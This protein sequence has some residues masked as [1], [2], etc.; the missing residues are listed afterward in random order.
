MVAA[1]APRDPEPMTAAVSPR[2]LEPMAAAV[3]PRDPE[4]MAAAVAPRDP[5]PM[6]TAVPSRDPEP[7]AAAVVL[8]DPETM[9]AAVVLR[10][11]EPM[12][13]A[14][15]DLA[16]RLN[17]KIEGKGP[18]VRPEREPPNV[19][20]TPSQPPP[21]VQSSLFLNK[22]TV[23]QDPVTLPCQHSFCLKCIEGVW[24]QTAGPGRF[25]CPQCRRKFNPTPSLERNFTLCNIV[26][27]YN[28]QP[29]VDSAHVVCDYCDE[30]PTPAVKTCLKCEISLCSLH[31]K[32]HLRNKVFSGHTLIEPVTDLTDRQCPDHKEV[33]KFYCKDDAECV[34]VPCAI[35]GKH[36]S[37]TLLSLDE[38]QSAIKEELMRKIKTFHRVQQNCSSKQ[39]DLEKSEAEIKKQVNELK[40]KFSNSF[41]EWRRKME[42]DEESILKLIDEEGLRALSQIRSCSEALNKRMKQI[43]LI[44]EE[45][46]SLVQRDHLSFIQNSKQLL[47]R[48]T[49]TQRGT[50]PDVPALTLNL[51]NISQLIQKRLNGWKKLYSDITGIIRRSSLS[52]DPKTANCNLVLSDD[53]RSVTWT[54][55]EQPYP[56]HPERFK[57]NFQVLCSQSFSSGSHSWDV[58]TDGNNWAIGIVYESVEREGEKSEFGNSSKSWCLDFYVDSL[59]A[60]HNSRFA[61]LPSILNPRIRVQLDY[62]AGT[63]LFYQV[64]DSLIHL[65]TFQ[66]TFTEP[67]FPAFYCRNKSLKLVN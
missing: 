33:L 36:K 15:G 67:V 22:I 57:N 27:K 66:T 37:H 24:T 21:E 62:E 9:A 49:E 2:Y 25:E 38:A 64:T 31:L 48:V 55:Q 39:R 19:R 14:V 59:S 32:P 42:E 34:C 65:H 61:S 44:N 52:L 10:D 1:V 5:E 6:P 43:T 16:L 53:L 28:S 8:R 18:K 50:D 46:Q 17:L 26:E 11:P 23:Y 54:E 58:E 60:G 7:M 45:T 41:S 12:A 30:N 51:Y 4:P 40:R 56:P 35:I 3:A 47:S 13:A 20:L 29:P 63:L